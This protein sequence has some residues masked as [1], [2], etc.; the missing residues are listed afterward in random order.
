MHDLDELRLVDLRTEDDEGDEHDARSYAEVG[1]VAHHG[2]VNVARFEQHSG[3]EYHDAARRT[4]EVYD[5]VRL[6]SQGLYRHVGHECDCGGAE[7][8]H[9]QK[10]HEQDRNK[11]NEHTRLAGA[12][13]MYAR[14]TCGGDVI[15]VFG[16]GDG[17]ARLVHG[18]AL[19]GGEL[20]A[21][22]LLFE[23][24][25]LAVRG[26]KG[27]VRLLVIDVLKRLDVVNGGDLVYLL[28]LCRID[29][30]QRNESHDGDDGADRD[31]RGAFAPLAVVPVGYGAE[32]REEEQRKDVVQRHDEAGPR[33]RHSEFVGQDEGDRIVVCLPKGANKEEGKADKNSAL[34]IK[35][36]C[37]TSE[38]S[39]FPPL[40]RKSGLHKNNCTLKIHIKQQIII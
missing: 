32:E 21:G 5:G 38:R 27:L 3:A 18:L 6:A 34:V 9:G 37:K 8:G 19:D 29:K 22:K 11:E 25:L 40:R 35:L 13:L 31:K 33:L 39:V 2:I 30:G 20:L 23:D 1:D 26:H 4:H 7:H 14:L 12:Y 10:H 16:G 24:K 36:H 28:E 15:R 17:L